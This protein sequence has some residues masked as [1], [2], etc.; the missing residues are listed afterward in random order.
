[1]FGMFTVSVSVPVMIMA[2]PVFSVV[3]IRALSVNI[4]IMTPAVRAIRIS[5]FL[6][7]NTHELVLTIRTLKQIIT[8]KSLAALTAVVGA[9]IIPGLAVRANPQDGIDIHIKN[10]VAVRTA[11]GILVLVHFSSAIRAEKCIRLID[12]IAI[13]TCC[14]TGHSGSAFSTESGIRLVGITAGGTILGSLGGI[15]AAQYS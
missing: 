15:L 11:Y 13:R 2:D 12:R 14:L 9:G 6:G 8:G 7:K 10:A 1:M 4:G 3:A 5:S